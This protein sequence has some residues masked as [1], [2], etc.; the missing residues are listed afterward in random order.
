VWI[1]GVDTGKGLTQPERDA[2][3]RFRRRGGGLLTARDHQDL[4]SCLATLPGP[5]SANYFQSVNLDPVAANRRR[6]DE[7]TKSVSWPNYHSGLN[8][9]VQEVRAIEPIHELLRR[10]DG[11]VIATFPAHPHE[12]A[13]GVPEDEPA[14]VIAKGR[15]T[16]TGR[17]FNLIVAFDGEPAPT[18]LGRAIVE[19]SFHHLVDYN[20][21][22]KRGA[23]SFVDD[24]EG[25]TIARNPRLLD[26]VKAY[27]RNAARWLARA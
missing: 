23:P 12:G 2:L 9:D 16:A 17:E 6:D 15:S 5:G 26:D 14:R 13:I 1:F 22:T 10:A 24:P 11:S 27:V 7:Y 4:G 19:S 3:V 25:T 8:G 21:D 20:W 18:S